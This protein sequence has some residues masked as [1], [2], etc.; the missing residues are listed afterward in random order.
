MMTRTA[1]R[2]LAALALALT[3]LP[4][5]LVTPALAHERR[6][7]GKYTFVV[8]FLNEP[9][10]SDQVNGIDLRIANTET[11]QPVE[12]AEK[13]L[14][15]EVTAGG[16]TMEVKLRAVYNQPGRYAADFI[17]T[18]AGQYTFRFSGTVD[19]QPVDER[20][21]SGPGRFHDV[22]SAAALQF[23]DRPLGSAELAQ[24][25]QAV[26]SAAQQ[27][28]TFALIG[29]GVG[30]L[31]LLAA[32]VTFATRPKMRP[33]GSVPLGAASTAPGADD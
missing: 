24:R 29:L 3:L 27:A 9:A 26:E 25:V 23:P 22:E 28:Q 16:R 17:P 12:G 10:I 2:A 4:L 5:A 31:G 8:G 20:F 21:E 33:A 13:T 32:I 1:L 18:R 11:K 14:K 19:G 7:V 15:A 30:A 6:E